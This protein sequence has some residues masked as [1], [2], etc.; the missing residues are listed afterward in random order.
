VAPKNPGLKP[1]AGPDYG[2]F[3][4]PGGP[5]KSLARMRGMLGRV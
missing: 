5:E 2:G 1:R 4:T 3:E